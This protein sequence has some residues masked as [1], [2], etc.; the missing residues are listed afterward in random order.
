MWMHESKSIP[1]H[2]EETC[3]VTHVDNNWCRVA[4]IIR[5]FPHEF[6]I[7][8]GKLKVKLVGTIGEIY[9]QYGAVARFAESL[10]N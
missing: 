9:A 6:T 1:Q 3:F 5:Q 10:R 4:T 7:R 8:D 2:R